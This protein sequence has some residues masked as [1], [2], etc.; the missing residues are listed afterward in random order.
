MGKR[1]RVFA[2]LHKSIFIISW[3]WPHTL[4]QIRFY[5]SHLF[6]DLPECIHSS[7]MRINMCSYH[8]LAPT[9]LYWLYTS[10][11]PCECIYRSL[12]IYGGHLNHTLTDSYLPI[13]LISLIW[14]YNTLELTSCCCFVF[15]VVFLGGGGIQHKLENHWNETCQ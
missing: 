11:M 14:S 15:F 12:T 13:P 7:I 10:Y 2:A 1:S 9:H 5:R 4:E 3:V 6:P 8:S